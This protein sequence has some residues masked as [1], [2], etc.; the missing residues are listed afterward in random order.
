QLRVDAA[1]NIQQER[2]A[3]AGFNGSG[4]ARNNRL[5]ERHD[6]VHGA[7]WRTYD[8]D[9]VQQNLVER[10]TL[11]P[12]RK[13]L[14]AFPLGPGAQGNN[15][16]HIGGEVIWNLPNGLQGYLLVNANGL[17]V[18]KAPTAIVSDPK[19]PDRARETG[20]SCMGG[21]YRVLH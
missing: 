1:V 2:V 9:A 16:Q 14:F 13:N 18:D 17:R 12:D 21:H 10:D 19:R 11:L 5:L 7:Y 6:A 4:V 15:F 3:R 8:F 20:I